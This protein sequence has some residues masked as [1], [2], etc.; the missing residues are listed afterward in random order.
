M[1]MKRLGR[2]P[3]RTRRGRLTFGLLVA[4]AIAAAGAVAFGGSSQS[5]LSGSPTVSQ[6]GC[7]TGP[8]EAEVRVTIYGGGEAACA[9]FDRAAA[10]A[11]EEFWRV[12]PAATEE[13]G[14]ELVCSMAK[15]NLTLEVRDTGAHFYGNKICARM[16]AQGWHE[17]EGP[18]QATERERETHE[19][20]AKAAI[21]QREEAERAEQQRTQAVEEHKHE[22]Q[23]HAEQAKEAAR[24]HKEEA[25]EREEQA[26]LTA[27]QQQEEDRQHQQE[28]RERQKEAAERAVEE[29]RSQEETHR[30]EEEAA[31]P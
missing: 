26:Q 14:R 5:S 18:G 10:R 1:N 30:S 19:T 27:Q 3:L 17:Q 13:T 2:F 6:E 23:Q 16:T 28:A 8:A 25:H 24:E 31:H 12:M 22:A 11:S 4:G 15:G 7:T 29:R 21:E 20:E 9:G